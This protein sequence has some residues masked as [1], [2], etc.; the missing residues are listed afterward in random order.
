MFYYPAPR[1]Q[2]H[3]HNGPNRSESIEKK[4]E[5]KEEKSNLSFVMNLNDTQS[6]I[7]MMRFDLGP[8]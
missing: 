5:K 4:K 8:K 7:K 3:A 1:I 6:G 2:T